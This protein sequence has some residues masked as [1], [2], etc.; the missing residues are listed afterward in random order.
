MMNKSGEHLQKPRSITVVGIIC[1]IL[2]FSVMLCIP[3]YLVGVLGVILNVSEFTDIIRQYGI[4]DLIGITITLFLI[5]P[6]IFISSIG[7]LMGRG[8]A[9]KIMI[10]VVS[11]SLFF[12]V[13]DILAGRIH[14][15]FIAL[16]SNGITTFI[17][18]FL[19]FYLNTKSIKEYFKNKDKIRIEISSKNKN[20]KHTT[21]TTKMLNLGIVVVA[22]G[23]IFW[24]IFNVSWME[25]HLFELFFGR[26]ALYSIG[27]FKLIKFLLFFIVHLF[28]GVLGLALLRNKSWAKK[29]GLWLFVFLLFFKLL[30]LGIGLFFVPKVVDEFL[31][32]IGVRYRHI[33]TPYK[34]FFYNTL[35]FIRNFS[36]VN[37]RKRAKKGIPAQIPV[38]TFAEINMYGLSI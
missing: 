25:Y 13:I 28:Y 16:V 7:I 14:L 19:L 5:A 30:S 24:G 18:I 1:I 2:S 21:F 35:L 15:E 11:I 27:W 37:E 17:N 34:R 26:G 4:Y 10:G 29:A 31:S 32:H 22:L 3:G 38:V 36:I 23:L 9:R 8:W 20:Y 6:F 12:N 33:W